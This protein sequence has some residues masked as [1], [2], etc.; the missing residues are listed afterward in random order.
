MCYLPCL[1][2]HFTFPNWYYRRCSSGGIYGG[3]LDN[4]KNQTSSTI[5]VLWD[6]F[7][8]LGKISS[9][10]PWAPHQKRRENGAFTWELSLS[11]SEI[12]LNLL[13]LLWQTWIWDLNGLGFFLGLG[14]MDGWKPFLF[15]F[16]LPWTTGSDGLWAFS[17]FLDFRIWSA[18]DWKN[19]PLHLSRQGKQP[20]KCKQVKLRGL[21]GKKVECPKFL[22]HREVTR[23]FNLCHTSFFIARY[24]RPLTMTWRI[25]FYLNSTNATIHSPVESLI[26]VQ[27]MMMSHLLP[28]TILYY[29][30][31]DKNI[32]LSISRSGK[33]KNN[34]YYYKFRNWYVGCHD[35]VWLMN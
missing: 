32:V 3:L 31:F 25:F 23:W 30:F 10:L 2:H 20:C 17:E 6:L 33:N 35:K 9:H 11:F 12:F 14:L 5:M 13:M 19:G 7:T 24:T 1:L 8:T 21:G 16:L 28:L 34:T 4:E 18:V 29:P 22:A 15:I 27:V 26:N